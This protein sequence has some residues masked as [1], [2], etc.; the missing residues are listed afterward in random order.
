ML[1]RGAGEG[2]KA[3]FEE[4]SLAKPL[5][6]VVGLSGKESL[7]ARTVARVAKA[8]R[9]NRTRYET[10][11]DQI[12]ALT[13]AGADAARDGAFGELG[14]L[15][16]VCHGYLN[17]LQ[18]STKELEEL[19][20]ISRR[21]GAAGAKLTGGGGGGSVVAL[22]PDGTGPVAAAIRAAGYEA[23]AFEVAKE[24]G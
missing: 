19:V 1:F 2:G 6:L 14:E 9:N 3:S 8:W 23:I 17:A 16:N 7:T 21:S 20:E 5:P 12:D 22:C 24:S 18:I 15:M 4:V 10:V 11:F 13:Q